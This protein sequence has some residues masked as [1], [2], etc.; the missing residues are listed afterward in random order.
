MNLKIESFEFVGRNEHWQ[1]A[2]AKVGDRWLGVA[3][4]GKFTRQARDAFQAQ[5]LP[6]PDDY[7]HVFAKVSD[8]FELGMKDKNRAML[9]VGAIAQDPE[10]G[11]GGVDEWLVPEELRGDPEKFRCLKCGE[12]G[13]NGTE[14]EDEFG[15]TDLSDVEG[16]YE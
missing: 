2:V 3:L 4:E 9:L 12:V 5:G 16:E 14:C 7:M 6:V 10:Q 15:D 8:G 11:F 13:C 1:F